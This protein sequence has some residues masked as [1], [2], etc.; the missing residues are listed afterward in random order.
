MLESAIDV[1][2]KKFGTD[3]GYYGTELVAVYKEAASE[4]QAPL[5]GGRRK[6]DI[7]DLVVEVEIAF[8]DGALNA[9]KIDDIYSNGTILGVEIISAEPSA[10]ASCR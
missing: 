9:E 2:P 3:S 1:G 5:D 4:E 7:V 6:R 8:K 10:T